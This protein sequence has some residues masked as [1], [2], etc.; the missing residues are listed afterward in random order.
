[1]SK[2]FNLKKWVTLV[3]A[4][5]RLSMTF[6]EEV[7]ISDLLQFALDGH[8]TLSVDFP[9]KALGRTVDEVT[10]SIAISLRQINDMFG[11]ESVHKYSIDL[12]Q[13]FSESV[14]AAVSE[15]KDLDQI[16][17]TEIS[18]MLNKNEEFGPVESLYGIYDLE[19]RYGAEVLD[20]K[21]LYQQ[22]I[23]GPS[24]KL[25]NINGVYVFG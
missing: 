2:L 3:D 21:H 4:A 15:A 12:S 5:K 10:E 14:R 16:L 23:G 13:Y 1:M 19:M 8:L 7:K 25:E 22:L 17:D 18:T 24:I 9:N 20:I 11:F 6:D